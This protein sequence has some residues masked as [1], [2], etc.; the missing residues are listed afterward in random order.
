MSGDDMI[1]RGCAPTDQP[2]LEVNCVASTENGQTGTVCACDTDLYNSAKSNQTTGNATSTNFI[3]SFIT[4]N[5][6]IIMFVKIGY[7]PIKY[8]LQQ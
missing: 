1:M 3:C 2:D 5:H 8:F 4:T 7:Y 6:N